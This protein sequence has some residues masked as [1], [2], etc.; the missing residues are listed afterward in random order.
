VSGTHTTDHTPYLKGIGAEFHYIPLHSSPVGRC[1]GRVV[2]SMMVTEDISDR[3]LRLPLF[4]AM[5]EMQV[6][7]VVKAIQ[8]YYAV[9]VP[10][11]PNK[12]RRGHDRTRKFLSK[13]QR[14]L[15]DR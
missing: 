13:K 3:I 14:G 2:G 4:Y 5:T 1:Y 12:K 8:E 15:N 6:Q 10:M 7:T 11:Q 9:E